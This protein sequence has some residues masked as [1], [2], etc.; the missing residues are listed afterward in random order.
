MSQ[1]QNGSLE[2]SAQQ[3]TRPSNE[4][5]PV[6]VINWSSIQNGSRRL[7]ISPKRDHKPENY[8]DFQLEFDP[9]LFSSLEQYL[10]PHMLNLSRDVKVQ[11]MRNILLHYLPESD[12]I[13]EIFNYCHV[14]GHAIL[15]PGRHRHGARP[16]TAGNRINLIL[17][18]RSSDFR[19][20]KKYKR[21]FSSWCG[22]CRR[23][24][25]E[26]VRLSVTAT[27][28]ELLKREMQSAS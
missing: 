26:R 19:E 24:K 16:T 14:P 13:R 2:S 8:E 7:R 28:Q 15:H 17:W 5:G 18:C 12:R 23:K 9:H 27:Q 4:H 6:R 21:D 22:E 1:N 10:P 11:Y 3:Q 25:E 20:L